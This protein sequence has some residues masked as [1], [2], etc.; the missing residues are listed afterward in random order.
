V[1]SNIQ[2]IRYGFS[3]SNNFMPILAVLIAS[4][5]LLF[6]GWLHQ[7]L[8][9]FAFV[10]AGW[11]ASLCLHEFGHAYA[12]HKGGDDTMAAKGYLELDPLK[13]VDPVNS[14]VLPLIFLAMGSIAFPGGAVLIEQHLIRSR[15]WLSLVS[16]AGPLANLA[17]LA[18]ICLL[19]WMG[20]DEAVGDPAF[21]GAMAYLGLMQLMAI[22]INMLPLP[23]LDGFG[24]L[25]PYLPYDMAM[26]ARRLAPVV[27]FALLIVFMS[28]TPLSQGFFRLIFAIAGGIGL[29]GG[30]IARG[31][32]AF[33][34]WR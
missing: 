5:L 23:G 12:A 15:L 10:M 33:R 22:V 19:F 2:P 17:V 29:D 27:P 14:V 20:A 25:E 18:V 26:S 7:G 8:A 28:V 6:N 31:M 34:F 13:Y 16:L 24:V 3:I 4:G 1:P 21:W 32:R 11:L 9:T 30:D